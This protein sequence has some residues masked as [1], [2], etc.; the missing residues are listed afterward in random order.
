MRFKSI[1]KSGL[2][3][4]L[5]IIMTV[6][7]FACNNDKGQAKPN[8]ELPSQLKNERYYFQ[9]GYRTDWK[10]NVADPSGYLVDTETNLVLQL[11]P[12]E[13]REV[14]EEGKVINEGTAIAG[15]EYTIYAY[16]SNEHQGDAQK[17]NMTSTPSEVISWIMDENNGFYFNSRFY[18]D[19]PRDTFMQRP[20]VTTYTAKFSKLQFLQISYTFTRDGEDW[21]GIYNFV[22][23]GQDFFIVTFEAKADLYEQYEAQ[24]NETIGDFRKVGWE[25]SNV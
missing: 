24:Y 1:L 2:L 6:S 15:V 17:I 16:K 4:I 19:S 11:V 22:M 5:A 25:T 20:D 13:G 9:Q 10:I 8:G 7:L 3:F 18:V 23:K 21:R 12:A 14:D